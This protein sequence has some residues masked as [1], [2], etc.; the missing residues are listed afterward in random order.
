MTIKV[1]LLL[2]LAVLTTYIVYWFVRARKSRG[3]SGGQAVPLSFSRPSGSP[4]TSSTLSAS[5]RSRRRP[6]SSSFSILPHLKPVETAP[7]RRWAQP[8]V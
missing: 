5:A 2:A 8:D 6:R 4:R 7:T 1:G 3:A